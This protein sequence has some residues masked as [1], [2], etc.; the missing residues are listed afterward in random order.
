[1][2]WFLAFWSRPSTATV[3]RAANARQARS[4]A[5][6]KQKRG[7]GSILAARRANPQDA[8]LIR[9]GV[10]VR[11]LRDGS[12]PQF[13]GARSRARARQQRSAFRHWL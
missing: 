11:R 4:R 5:Q 6:H 12:S 10:W 8:R 13:G 3:V 7:Y 9:R 1:M 2:A